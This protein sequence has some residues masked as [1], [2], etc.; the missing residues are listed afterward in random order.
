M[1]YE[2]QSKLRAV[3]FYMA[4]SPMRRS[5]CQRLPFFIAF[6]KTVAFILPG[7]FLQRLFQMS[8]KFRAER[9]EL[10]VLVK[11]GGGIGVQLPCAVQKLFYTRCR[12]VCVLFRPCET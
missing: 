11:R 3:V 9:F 10:Y 8:G 6:H 12:C 4:V 5:F 1:E 7:G 2:Q